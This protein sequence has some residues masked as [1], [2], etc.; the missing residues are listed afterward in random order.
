MTED[1]IKKFITDALKAANTESAEA[2]KAA[3][4]EA[5]KNATPELIKPVQDAITALTTRVD[6][7]EKK[8][9]ADDG[10]DAGDEDKGASGGGKGKKGA[11]DIDAVVAAVAKALEPKLKVVDELHAKTTKAEGD[12]AN[13]ARVK[14]WLKAN[15]P[16]LPKAAIESWE[17]KLLAAGA[18]DEAG[19]AAAFEA[20]LRLLKPILG[21]EAVKP[22]MADFKGEG[23]KA[24]D[25]ASDEK[26]ASEKKAKEILERGTVRTL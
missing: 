9:T 19:I 7:V 14:A 4:G 15:R 20:E 11:V 3:I 22:F 21:E 5:L 17:A 1:Q 8:A 18:K 23:G 16:N 6:S 12:A 24:G 26:A 10:G 2:I 13:T 25:T